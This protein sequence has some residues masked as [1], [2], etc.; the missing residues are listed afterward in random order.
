MHCNTILHQNTSATYCINALQK[1]VAVRCWNVPQ[2]TAS[3]YCINILRQRT[4][5]T[6]CKNIM[7][8][9]TATYLNNVLQQHGIL[10]IFKISYWDKVT[11][12]E[13]TAT[14]T[15]FT[16]LLK[17]LQEHHDLDLNIKANKTTFRDT[18]SLNK[19]KTKWIGSK[20]NFCI[21]SVPG[22]YCGALFNN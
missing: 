15:C 13:N 12:E 8:Q 6:H 7:Q 4:A 3:T 21:E 10:T 9:H 18:R 16:Y 5:T 2:H 20:P 1:Y 22:S 17:D 11:N 19:Y 14:G